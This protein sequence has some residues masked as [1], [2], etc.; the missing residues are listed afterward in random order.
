MKKLIYAIL[1]LLLCLGIYS[2]GKKDSA[3]TATT[4]SP[5]VIILPYSTSALAPYNANKV[6]YGCSGTDSSG[7]TLAPFFSTSTHDLK[8]RLPSSKWSNPVYSKQGHKISSSWESL[9]DG[10]IDMSL[11]QA[12]V[13]YDNS[14]NAGYVRGFWS[15]T[16]S[17]GT[18]SG[19]NCTGW[20]SESTSDNT[21][22]GSFQF[23]DNSRWID[24][25]T[26]ACND[27]TDTYFLCFKYN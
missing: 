18:F 7:Y 20:S 9:W 14:S 11:H 4:A 10:N 3:S 5:E 21:T 16:K 17:D 8:D 15:A 6:A 2:C 12:E 26:Q 1:I 13:V 19:N 25:D 27:G 22:R 24:N 23:K